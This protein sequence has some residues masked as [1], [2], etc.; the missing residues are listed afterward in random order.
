MHKYYINKLKEGNQSILSMDAIK[1]LDKLSNC[2]LK[3]IHTYSK[4]GIE[5]NYSNYDKDYM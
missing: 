2:F 4:I 1:A 5:E 3:Y